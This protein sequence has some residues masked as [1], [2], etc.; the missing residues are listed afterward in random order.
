MVLPQSRFPSIPDA[1]ERIEVPF[2]SLEEFET[3]TAEHKQSL[4]GQAGKFVKNSLR[5][6]INQGEWY[7]PDFSFE[8]EQMDADELSEEETLVFIRGFSELPQEPIILNYQ[9][10]ALEQAQYDLVFTNSINGVPQRRVNVLWPGEES[11]VLDLSSLVTQTEPSKNEIKETAEPIETIEQSNKEPPSETDGTSTFFS[12]LRQGFVHVLPLGLDHILFVLGI[13]MLSRK[14]RPLI[15]QVSVFTVAHTIT[16]A[17]ATLD[18]V[19]APSNWVEPII[20]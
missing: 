15:L 14:F 10:Q 3:F 16:L 8:F 6:R 2:L 13:F 19:S 4:L 9:I 1:S 7:L 12:F 11:F 20:A 18:L 17:L 5:V